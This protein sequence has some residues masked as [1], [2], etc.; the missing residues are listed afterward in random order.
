MAP[1]FGFFFA[2]FL[3]IFLGLSARSDRVRKVVVLLAVVSAAA[4][5]GFRGLVGADTAAYHTAFS[6]FDPLHAGF[7]Q[8]VKFEPLFMIWM[9]GVKLFT[10]NP[11]YF[12]LSL[13]VLQ[14]GLL[15]LIV[16]DRAGAFG[17]LFA[18]FAFFYLQNHFNTVRS[19]IAALFLVLA[20][21]RL[22]EDRSNWF[23]LVLSLSFHFGAIA[24]FPFLLRAVSFFRAAAFLIAAAGIFY[25]FAFDYINQKVLFYFVD[26]AFYSKGAIFIGP[27]FI[28]TIAVIV[29]L[30]YGAN[31]SV[32]ARLK[33]VFLFLVL[34]KVLQMVF[35][36]L[37]RLQELVF[38][39]WLTATAFSLSG[40]IFK[41]PGLVFIVFCL[42]GFYFVTFNAV[43]YDIENRIEREKVYGQVRESLFESPLVPYRTFF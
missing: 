31:E 9:A 15:Y 43:R 27:Y 6:E 24:L 35:P 36:V 39:V 34:L 23:Y 17:F 13:S 5:G 3:L 18:Y 16:K 21:Q 10:N 12:M 8:W 30:Q 26:S 33:L 4:F 42:V 40:R 41:L 1:Y 22:E 20:Y 25:L 11:Y 38:M 14:G 37:W 7:E 32:G 28:F 19:G 29:F 2:E